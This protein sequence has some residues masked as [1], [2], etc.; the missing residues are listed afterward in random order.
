[1]AC[2]SWAGCLSEIDLAAPATDSTN[3][4]IRGALVAGADPYV[5]VRITR[6]SNFRDLEI[7]E[8][9]NGAAV[10]LSDQDAHQLSLPMVEAGLYRL[11]LPADSSRD[12][13]VQTGNSYLLTVTAP[14]GNVYQSTAEFLPAVP[15]PTAIEETRLSRQVLNEVGNVVEQEFIRFLINTPLE[16]PEQPGRARLRWTFTGTYRFRESNVSSPFPPTA[17]ICYFTDPLDLDRVIAYNGEESSRSELTNFLLLE[18]PYNYRFSEGFYLTVSQQALSD[19]AYKYWT[20]IGKAVD[21]SGTFFESPPGKIRGNIRNINDET[22]EVFGYFYA[23][24]EAILRYHVPPAADRV[25]PYCPAVVTN[26]A[27][28]P[29]LCLNCLAKPGST[30]IK[31]DFWED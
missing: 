20:D 8:P 17:R 3:I 18:E 24:Q 12:L 21:I 1:M 2:L 30:T 10:V 25:R 16:N 29:S 7:P 5:A 28:A 6:L 9:V 27:D 23:T 31:P 13:Q 15:I 14:D 4:A 26:S 11:A 22:E 19:G